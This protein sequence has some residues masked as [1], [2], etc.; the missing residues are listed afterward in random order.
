MVSA[1]A[2]AAGNVPVLGIVGS[3]DPYLAS[4]TALAAVMP[5]MALTI[6]PGADHDSTPGPP[7]FLAA[8]VEFL[9]AHPAR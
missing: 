9:R 3:E 6:I 2:L 4:F 8:L 5:C 7:A 1:T